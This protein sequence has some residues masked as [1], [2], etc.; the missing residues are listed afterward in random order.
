MKSIEKNKDIEK[1]ICSKINTQLIKIK[2]G[3]DILKYELS[4]EVY[5]DKS[6]IL[7][8]NGF[9]GSI[10]DLDKYMHK[11]ISMY[12]KNICI[13]GITLEENTYYLDNKEFNIN[14]ID[15]ILETNII[16]TIIR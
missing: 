5:Y 12:I 3:Y 10:W 6:K 1:K 7:C 9:E 15:N 11:D 8:F 14:N 13:N 16:I 2:K 4:N